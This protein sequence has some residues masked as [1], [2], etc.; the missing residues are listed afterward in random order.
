MSQAGLDDER[1]SNQARGSCSHV[2]N[3]ES[4]SE[5]T[6]SSDHQERRR[7]RLDNYHGHPMN[8][9]AI[10]QSIHQRNNSSRLHANRND[11][12]SSTLES[13]PQGRNITIFRNEDDAGYRS[14]SY[15]K[16]GENC[17]IPVNPP[18][19]DPKN[20]SIRVTSDRQQH[21]QA[22]ANQR[23]ANATADNFDLHYSSQLG[24]PPVDD[25]DSKSKHKHKHHRFHSDYH[26]S[27]PTLAKDNPS[28][29]VSLKLKQMP[30]LTTG[31]TAKNRPLDNHP[32]HISHGGSS[33]PLSGQRS[34][35]SNDISDRT[36]ISSQQF[37]M[38]ITDSGSEDEYQLS[39][40]TNPI[41]QHQLSYF[42]ANPYLQDYDISSLCRPVG[43][44]NSIVRS[45]IIISLMI[46]NFAI[47]CLKL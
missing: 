11:Y 39:L 43:S 22:H 2:D 20:N 18:P 23:D 37:A 33:S 29:G 8:N 3:I 4:Q 46:T 7:S 21:H 35:Q 32:L 47:H 13:T 28:P 19:Y 34:S 31:L 40:H 10:L 24:L 5:S 12:P 41:H 14:G 25:N 26:R 9:D 27:A 30:N 1:I 38:E 44:N 15:E 36:S 17:Y 45:F 42:S 16:N 6:I